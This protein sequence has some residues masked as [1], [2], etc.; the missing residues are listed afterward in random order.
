MTLTTIVKS[1]RFMK[2]HHGCVK[3]AWS[4]ADDWWMLACIEVGMVL[5]WT[6]LPGP[7]GWLMEVWT[8]KGKCR[9][10]RTYFSTSIGLRMINPPALL[11]NGM[12]CVVA[13]YPQFTIHGIICIHLAGSGQRSPMRIF[14]RWE[15]VCLK[16][17]GSIHW[18]KTSRWV[19]WNWNAQQNLAAQSVTAFGQRFFVSINV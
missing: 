7:V 6:S 10:C 9:T 1:H 4:H 11:P 8:S 14:W 2:S 12:N 15:G 17:H 16:S 18:T 13:V 19:H 5:Y 3:Q